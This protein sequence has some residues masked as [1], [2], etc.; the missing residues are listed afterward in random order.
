MTAGSATLRTEV[1]E[2][3]EEEARRRDATPVPF[4]MT[5]KTKEERAVLIRQAAALVR[6]IEAGLDAERS[7]P[8]T[9][10]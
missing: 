6:A 10:P 4:W 3:I 5:P 9:P 8:P 1:Y 7:S 2:A